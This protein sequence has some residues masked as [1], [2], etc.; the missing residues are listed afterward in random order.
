MRIIMRQ[1]ID[2]LLNLK[3]HGLSHNDLKPENIL[4]D[5]YFIVQIAD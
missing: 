5:K 2:A 3:Q 4:I 1:L